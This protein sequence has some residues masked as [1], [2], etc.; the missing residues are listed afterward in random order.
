MLESEP[1]LNGLAATITE[2]AKAITCYLE[3]NGLPTPSFAE[4]S[5]PG[6]PRVPDVAIPR[7]NLINALFELQHLILGPFDDIFT[8]PLFVCAH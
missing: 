5:P 2:A 3:A 8:T 6:Y 1:T 7:L 4:D